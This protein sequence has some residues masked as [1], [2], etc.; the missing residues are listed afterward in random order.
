MLW[1]ILG[2]GAGGGFPQWNCACRNCSAV[3]AHH[4]DFEPR[5]QDSVAIS[6]DG[7]S[8]FLLNASPDVLRQI[9]ATPALWPR[10]LRRSPIAGIVLTNGDMDHVL[11][12]FQ[13]REWHPLT[14]YAT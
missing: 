11:G 2:S 8:W 6:G 12:L 3:R 5:T 4:A 1:R 13:L 7:A 9:H 10:E 14:I